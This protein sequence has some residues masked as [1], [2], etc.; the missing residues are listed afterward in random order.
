MDPTYVYYY[1][2][3]SSCEPI[4][5]VNAIDLDNA[6]EQISIIKHLSPDSIEELFVIQRI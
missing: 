1:R 3:D 2:S 5:Q 4:G 6:I